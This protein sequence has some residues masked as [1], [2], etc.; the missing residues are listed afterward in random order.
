M[1]FEEIIACL[2]RESNPAD[3]AGMA[4]VGIRPDR[5]FG[6]K[7]PA[8]RSLAK[9]IGK[10]HELAARLWRAGYRE[11]QILAAM[12]DEP[13]KV[14]RRQMNEW[15]QNFTYWEICDQCCMNL[16]YP[17]P[18]AADTAIKW[19]TAAGEQQ[20]RASFAL[21]AVIAWKDKR[22]SDEIL[23]GF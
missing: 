1:T 19:L 10:N 16:F 9:R 14:T 18:F 5:A 12:I 11:T 7:L 6:T 13:A 3:L 8:L 23:K 20:K 15:A 22:A 21:M 17:L 4:R 2:K